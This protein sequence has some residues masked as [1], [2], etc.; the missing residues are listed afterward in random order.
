[1]KE[2]EFFDRAIS[3]EGSGDKDIYG[4][5]LSKGVIC[6]DDN[7]EAFENNINLSDFHQKTMLDSRIFGDLF[8]QLQ[9]HKSTYCTYLNSLFNCDSSK[10]LLP[11]YVYCFIKEIRPSNIPSTICGEM[12]TPKMA[13]LMRIPTIYNVFIENDND[14]S[15]SR[16][17]KIASVDF[18]PYGYRFEDLHTLGACF[19]E[20]DSIK[21]CIEDFEGVIKRLKKEG[22]ICLTAK[23]E[24][25]L[26]SSFIEQLLFRNVLCE[27]ADFGAKNMGILIGNEGECMLAPIFDLE[28]VF[29]GKRSPCFYTKFVEDGF[30]YINSKY[31]SV[32]DVFMTRLSVCEKEK[33]L[34]KLIRDADF[35][36]DFRR[37]RITRLLSENSKT[38]IDVWKKVRKKSIEKL[39]LTNKEL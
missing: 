19:H 13:N 34:I 18:T 31:S 16:Y 15:I 5:T 1:M 21:F 7:T 14:N 24:Y 22:E 20:G 33:S 27:D 9:S 25:K 29:C 39:G 2:T 38:M 35:I 3:L 28:Y 10:V 6:I 12:I 8:S 37:N 36:T 30:E 26:M 23:D 11:H 4:G 17:S 32:S